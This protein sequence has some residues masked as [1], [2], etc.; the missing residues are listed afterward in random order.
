[1]LQVVPSEWGLYAYV[2]A[3]TIL[4]P[5][6]VILWIELGG[7]SKWLPLNSLY[8]DVMCTSPIIKGLSE[9][10]LVPVRQNSKRV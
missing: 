10:V 6:P 3:H 1:M 9:H 8:H 5:S 4:P 7:K 2:I